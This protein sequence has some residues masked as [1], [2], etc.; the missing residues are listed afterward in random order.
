MKILI[1]SLWS[2]SNASIGGTE[3]FVIDLANLL[4]KKHSVTIL[5][6]GSI[7]LDIKNVNTHSLNIIEKLDEYSLSKYLENDGFSDI[8][9]KINFFIKENKFNI[10][11]CNSLVFVD[12]IKSIPVIHTVHTNP[13]ELRQSFSLKI[14]DIILKNIKNDKNSIYVTP[15]FYS[16]TSFKKLTK[17]IALVIKHGFS[18][19]IVLKN[20]KSLRYKY[21]ISNKEIVFCVPSRL[22]IE[23]KGQETLLKALRSIKELFLPFTVVLGGCDEQYLK[24]KKYLQ[25]NYSDLKIVIN[26][27][28]NKSDMYS[29]SDVIILPS[30]TES[31][32]YAA[33]ESAMTGFPLFLSDIPPYKEIAKDNN[34]IFLFKNNE[35][36]L[37]KNLQK[38]YKIIL[39]HKIVSPPKK[40]KN[41][42]SEDIMLQKYISIY[43]KCIS[44]FNFH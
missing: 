32:G 41:R 16:K 37:A 9:L 25:E 21:G 19:E 30:K 38:K 11:H 40:W 29:L 34:Y 13:E 33:L 24:N 28:S 12:L 10:I 39:D 26:G 20:K 35:T 6:L 14:V 2:I 3:K 7:D 17:K 18:S 31:F 1:I 27:F 5:S 43:K 22:E 42:Y 8:K 44:N 23:Q 4:S 36:E 15:S